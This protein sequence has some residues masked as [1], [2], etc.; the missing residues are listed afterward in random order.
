MHGAIDGSCF[1]GLPD[2][3]G[4]RERFRIHFIWESA[5]GRHGLQQATRHVAHADATR[6]AAGKERRWTHGPDY[7]FDLGKEATGG[8]TPY[9]MK[10]AR[11]TWYSMQRVKALNGG[12]AERWRSGGLY[13]C[14]CM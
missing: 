6:L 5:S 7:L 9:E 3:H 8:T 12:A 2:A 11:D 10:D 1:H 14:L 13:A 4:R